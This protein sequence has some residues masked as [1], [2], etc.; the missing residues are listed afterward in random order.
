[1]GA[2]NRPYSWRRRVRRNL[3]RLSPGNP[4]ALGITGGMARQA[5][6]HLVFNHAPLPV[7]GAS[8][9]AIATSIRRRA[10]LSDVPFRLASGSKLRPLLGGC[11]FRASGKPHGPPSASSSQGIVVSPGGAPAP[12]ERRRSV[13]LLPAGAASDSTCMTPHDSALGGP[14]AAIIN[15]PR[16]ARIS[17]RSS[18]VLVCRRCHRERDAAC[19]CRPSFAMVGARGRSSMV[20]RQLPNHIFSSPFTKKS[21]KFSTSP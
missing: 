21:N 12:P 2:R 10:A 1:L 4:L 8:R 14:N 18:F 3:S 19:R 13:R 17:F 20:E 11:V 15:P 16:R 9:R 7:R 6:R 5:A